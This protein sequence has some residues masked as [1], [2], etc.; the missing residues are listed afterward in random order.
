[1]FFCSPR[2]SAAAA[3][4]RLTAAPLS[5]AP[6][7][8]DNASCSEALA[9][10]TDFLLCPWPLPAPE[11][12]QLGETLKMLLNDVLNGIG[13]WPTQFFQKPGVQPPHA[14]AVRTAVH[15]SVQPDRKS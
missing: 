5:S 9:K 15:V 3:R 4:S 14:L 10:S 2:N 7:W 11:L 8:K 6:P 1:M 13:H 12:R